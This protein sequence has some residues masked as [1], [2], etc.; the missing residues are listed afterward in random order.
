[1][2]SKKTDADIINALGKLLEGAN[3][4]VAVVSDATGACIYVGGTSTS[5]AVITKSQCDTLSGAWTSGGKC[6]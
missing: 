4:S 2:T 1:M 6:P 3:R 5:C